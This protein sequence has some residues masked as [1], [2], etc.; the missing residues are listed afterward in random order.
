MSAPPETP[1]F[2]PF[3]PTG[4]GLPENLTPHPPADMPEIPG[5]GD[6]MAALSPFAEPLDEEQIIASLDLRR[7]LPLYVPHRDRY[8]QHDFHI[9]NDQPQE[10]AKAS[11]QG[12]SV[13][14]QHDLKNAFEGK[15]S[16][17]DRTG[18]IM[19]PVLMGRSKKITEILE[20]RERQQLHD[21]YQ[22]MD[23]R[24]KQFNS[25]YADTE[26]VIN[27]GTTRGQF[28]GAGWRIKVEK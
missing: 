6:A 11:R 15:V 22:S 10:Y 12:W 25:K 26:A 18:K 5:P 27:S 24:N 7:P 9:I 8:P 14:D 16:G 21:M 19:K 23:P 3:V 13:A 4:T 17:T 1:P 28:S 2:S 20:K